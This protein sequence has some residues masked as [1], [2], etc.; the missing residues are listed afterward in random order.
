MAQV[1]WEK[2][3]ERESDFWK[4]FMMISS[5]S[6]VRIVFNITPPERLTTRRGMTFV[7]WISRPAIRRTSREIVARLKR[8]GF[9]ARIE[10]EFRLRRN[11]LLRVS[12][13]LEVAPLRR[14]TDKSLIVRYHRFCQAYRNLY[15]PFHLAIYLDDVEDRAMRW[16][17]VVLGYGL[18]SVSTHP[19][20][21]TLVT[22]IRLSPPQEEQLALLRLAIRAR[23]QPTAFHLDRML[24]T[25]VRKY[26]GLPVVNDDVKPWGRRYF[27][28]RLQRLLQLPLL[29]VERRARTLTRASVQHRRQQARLLAQLKAPPLIRRCFELIGLCVWIRI[30]ARHAFAQAHYASRPLFTEL[31]RRC[32]QTASGVKWFTSDELDALIRFRREPPVETLRARQRVAVLLYRRGRYQILEGEAAERFIHRELGAPDRPVFVRQLAGVVVYPGQASGAV[33]VVRSQHDA[34]RMPAGAILVVRMTTP[35]IVVAVHRAQAIITDEGGITCHAAIVAREFR[36]PCVVGTRV[37][38]NVLRDGDKVEVD[39]NRG[40]VKI[41]ARTKR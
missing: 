7:H 9:P 5:V 38:T 18:D 32:G 22:S 36:I 28:S 4:N 8:H 27:H 17:G 30:A 41:L 11:R 21:N 24:Q 19:A 3:V 2:L 14:L 6:D 25:H 1:R 12:H 37:A 35:E 20:W 34:Q 40:I 33:T 31:G 29:E 23:Q 39:A 15:A 16:L 26:A 10:R 13:K